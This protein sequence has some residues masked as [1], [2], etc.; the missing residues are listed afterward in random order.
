MKVRLVVCAVMI[1]AISGCTGV[2]GEHYLG[3]P[4]SPAWFATASSDTI[5][6]YYGKRCSAY[7]FRPGTDAM[8]QCIES[9]AQGRRNLNVAR[10]AAIAQIGANLQAAQP[11]RYNCT[12]INTGIT[13]QTNCY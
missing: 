3:R 6:A 7:G 5:A 8:A 11:H 9:E 10:T 4:G 12:S 13:V 1:A 2:D